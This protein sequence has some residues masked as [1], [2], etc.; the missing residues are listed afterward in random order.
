MTTGNFKKILVPLD[1]SKNSERGLKKAIQLASQSDGV[2]TGLFVIP[3]LPV[4]GLHSLSSIRKKQKNEANRVLSQ[5]KN[6]VEQNGIRFNSRVATGDAGSQIAR[7]ADAH[8]VTVIGSR[9]RGAAKS[10]FF[11]STSNY[12]LHQAK[13]PVLIVK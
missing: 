7:L 5:A 8:D 11:G 13:R 1:G 4:T 3:P 12:V 9:G 2:L 10:L 6:Q